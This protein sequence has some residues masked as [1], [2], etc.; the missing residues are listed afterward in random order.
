MFGLSFLNAGILI[1]VIATA[2]PLLIHLFV[3]NKPIK[4]LFSSLKFIREIIEER[5]KKMT[6]NQ[7]LLMILR[8]LIILFTI[9][10]VSRPI[11]QLPFI[12]KGNYHP[13][14]AI[15]FIL[16]TSPSM[17]YVI[18][19]KTQIQHGIE[20]I[21]NIQL[22]MNNRDASLL[23]T[24]DLMF[25]SLRSRLVYGQLPDRDFH[26]IEF[27][28]TPEPINRLIHQ[29][30]QELA[31]SQ[32]LHKE[33]FV[34]SDMQWTELPDEID[35]PIKFIST[36]SDSIRVNLS[37]ENASVR[38][39]FIAGSLQRIAEFEV[40]N[41]S[42]LNQRDQIVRLHINGT[43][44]SE[45]MVDL[46]PYERKT[47]FFVINNESLEWNWGWVE[48]RND[49]FLPDNRYY[50]S[51]YSDP[52]PRIGVITEDHLRDRGTG[53]LP[54]PITILAELFLGENGDI[55]IIHPNN[56]QLADHEKYHFLIFY[57]TNYSSRIQTLIRELKSQNIQSMFIFHPDMNDISKSFFQTQY[58]LEMGTLPN[59]VARPIIAYH[60]WHRIIGDFDFSTQINLQ[61]IPVFNLGLGI[62]NSPLATTDLTPLFIE[63]NDIFININF[64][65][66]GQNFF[67]HPSFPIIVYR[68]FS[69]ISK[70]DGSLNQ[71]L[72]GDTFRN[73]QGILISPSGN[74][75]DASILSFR[76]NEP[77]IWNFIENQSNSTNNRPVSQNN[78]E[79]T[80]LSVNMFDFENQS[81][82]NPMNEIKIE[83]GSLQDF[84]FQGSILQQDR[85]YEIWKILLWVVLAFLA[86]EMI[87]VLI[88]QKKAQV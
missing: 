17:D 55:D 11:L 63:N 42:P 80:M 88:F 53:G 20:I 36:F 4:V 9:F 39:D 85:G 21:R 67:S 30:Q 12:N 50:F 57:L 87:V 72:L 65:T 64:L 25:N 16:D 76:F 66:S 1:A 29:A 86:T 84:D 62:N 71:Y 6:L 22:D 26:N 59:R 19:Q 54:R 81:R 2:I 82:H 69:W 31:K 74:D 8:M 7:L 3:K 24:S 15:A 51:F 48:V 23:L 43:N 79:S 73:K 68:S 70:Y 45:K 78:N 49:R 34:I 40:V 41:Y 46:Q 38:K 61:A 5:K 47:D 58:G 44:V 13:P 35:V 37:I 27:T 33:I 32:F 83:N 14:T 60:Q 77:G 18:D 10:A 52:E 75:Y 28:W 56:L